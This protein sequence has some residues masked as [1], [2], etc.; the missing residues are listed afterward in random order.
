ME[1]NLFYG[2][3]TG[4]NKESADD[5]WSSPEL[6]T[7]FARYAPVTRTI[8]RAGWEPITDATASDTRVWVERW[9]KKPSTTDAIYVSLRNESTVSL[10][11][12]VTV[13]LR[14]TVSSGFRPRVRELIT[15]TWRSGTLNSSRTQVSFTVGV[16]AGSTR[17]V[18]VDLTPT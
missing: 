18:R 9:G 7:L 5:W 13:S 10:T 15:G 12:T 6:R 16:P 2:I 8:N 3:F 17:V 4:P 11:P 14:T 1:Q